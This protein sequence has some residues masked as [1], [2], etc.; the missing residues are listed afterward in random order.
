MDFELESQALMAERRREVALLDLPAE[1]R[2][3]KPRDAM[4][5]EAFLHWL[6]MF[7][8]LGLVVSPSLDSGTNPK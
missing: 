1:A 7:A 2:G 3:L 5:P 4:E 6:N 8:A